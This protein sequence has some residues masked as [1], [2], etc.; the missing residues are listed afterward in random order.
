MDILESIRILIQKNFLDILTL[1][2]NLSA[3]AK[4]ETVFAYNLYSF[5]RFLEESLD[6]AFDYVDVRGF[7]LLSARKYLDWE[8]SP[9]FYRFNTWWGRTLP[10]LTPEVNVVVKK[11]S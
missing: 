4:G 10:S 8:N 6:R 2:W 7:R 11:R 9:G 3:K 1:L 5:K